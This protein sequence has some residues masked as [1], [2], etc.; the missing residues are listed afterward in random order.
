V[1]GGISEFTFA[2]LY[3]FRDA[4]HYAFSRLEDGRVVILGRDREAPFFMT[5]FGLPEPPLL[6][7][8]MRDHGTLKCVSRN[9]KTELEGLGYQVVE[10]RDNFDYLYL[11]QDLAELAGR[12][13]MKK[14]NLV[15]GFVSNHD[16]EGKPLL[17][18]YL[19]DALE[20]L[21]RW[22][23]ERGIP[24]DYDAAREAL[25]RSEELQLCGGIYYA[26]GR[27]AAY[28]LGEELDLGTSFVIHFEKAL[29]RYRGLYQFVNQTFASI[30]PE[31]YL[32]LN[33]EQDLGDEGLR[34]AKL[35][36][37][38]S[39]FVEKYRARASGLT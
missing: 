20:V 6:D 31:T 10:D 23:D 29:A 13:F 24:G 33:R 16:C 1:G 12:R 22:R 25:E 18:E 2:N 38:P 35:S 7:R 14:R 26:D 4:H 39:G 36:Y 15:K 17:D 27:P 5:P 28:C 3:L 30:I 32:T 8:L 37:R 21:D 19:P 9:R 11:R 34:H